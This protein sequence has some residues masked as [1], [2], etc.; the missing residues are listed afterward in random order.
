MVTVTCNGVLNGIWLFARMFCV[1]WV[2]TEYKADLT[3]R[4][5]GPC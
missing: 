3:G 4:P 1:L 5:G 2:S